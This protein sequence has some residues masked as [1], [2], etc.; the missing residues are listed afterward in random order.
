MSITRV[1]HFEAKPDHEAELFLFMQ[2][3]VA[4]V[5]RAEGCINCQLLKG[6]ENSAQLVVIEEWVSIAHHQAA[7]S[8]IPKERIEK[9]MVFFAKPPFGVYYTNEQN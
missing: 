3:V 4:E 7:A 6:A 2:D 1:N 8:I 5:R 9:A